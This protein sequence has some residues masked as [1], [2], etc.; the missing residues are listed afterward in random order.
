MGVGKAYDVDN[1]VKTVRELT[2]TPHL[3]TNNKNRRSAID[4]RTTR[5]EGYRHS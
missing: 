2:V 5:H 1:F 3:A 4:G